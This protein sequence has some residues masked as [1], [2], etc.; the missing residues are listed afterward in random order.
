V[1][2]DTWTGL[3]ASPA[4]SEYTEEKKVLNVTE[5]WAV[6]WIKNTDAGKAWAEKYGFKAPV[7]FIPEREC[8]VD[9]PHPLIV[10]AGLNENQVVTSPPLDIYAVVDVSKDFKEFQ[11]RYGLGDNPVEWVK[12]GNTYTRQIKQ[13]ELLISWDMKDVPPGKF[14]LNI[15]LDGTNGY[16]KKSLHLLNQIPT[17]TPT[18]TA[19][20]TSTPTATST[21]TLTPTRTITPTAT[22][23]ETPL[24]P[25][26]TPSPTV[27]PTPYPTM[28]LP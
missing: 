13:P 18:P 11:L 15:R 5:K 10:F 1:K 7:T 14:T 17:A 12:L 3:R 24:P 6:R 27:T 20:V 8:R 23:T 16:A 26:I 25:T 21:R 28:G 22:I 19:T 4:C 9:D 2:I